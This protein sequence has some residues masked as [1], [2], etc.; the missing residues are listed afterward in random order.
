[1]LLSLSTIIFGI[2]LET[3]IPSSNKASQFVEFTA[4]SALVV[5]FTRPRYVAIHH[6]LEIDL[7]IIC[8]EVF[9]QI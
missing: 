1:M 5:I 2:V 8:E 6:H 4:P 3:D 9:F 7:E